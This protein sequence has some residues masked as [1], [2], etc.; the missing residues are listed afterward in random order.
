M[1]SEPLNDDGRGPLPWG[2]WLAA[3]ACLAVALL[4]LLGRLAP[5]SLRLDLGGAPTS[6]ALALLGLGPLAF[7]ASTLERGKAAPALRH[8]LAPWAL[9]A[10]LHLCVQLSGGLA[11][12]LWPAYPL[13]ILLIVRHA[14]LLPG[15]SACAV[16]LLLEGYPLWA[17]AQQDG[18]APWPRALALLLPPAGLLLGLLM[19]PAPLGAAGAQGRAARR[20]A[21]RAQEDAPPPP[22]QASASGVAPDLGVLGQ[23]LDVGA[24][25]ARDLGASLDLVFHSHPSLNSLSLWWGDEQAVSLAQLRLR[26]GQGQAAARVEAGQGHLGLVLRERHSVSIEPLAPSAAAGLPW[27]R[28]PYAAQALRVL[29]LSDEGRLVGLLAA[30]KAAEPAFSADEAA[31][32]ESLGRQLVGHAQRAA[33]LT[34]LQA[35][36]GRTQRLYEAAKALGQDLDREALLARFGALLAT[37]VASDS[38]ALGM[39]E[40]DG[41]PL[42]RVAGHGYDPAAALDMSWERSSALAGTLLQAEGALLF[43]RSEGGQVPAALL[44][45][46]QGE[47]QHFLLAPL[48]V[49]GRLSGVLKLDRR[50]QP[51]GEEERDVA[52][53]FASQAAVILEHARLYSLHLRQATTDGL[54][55]LY[56]HRY[57]QERLA[58]EVASAERTGKPLTL[59]LTD[60][61]LFKKFN[62]TFGHQEGD[63]VLRKVAKLC[64]DH[65]RPGKDIVCR[66]GGE[67]FVVIMPDCDVV[68]GRQVI[69]ALRAFSAEHMIGGSGPEARAITISVGLA[70]HPQAGRE[71]RELIHAA[72]EALYKAKQSGRNR[73]CSYKDL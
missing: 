6:A 8:P 13:L 3:L 16:L 23:G 67:E 57:F 19:E 65:V 42:L 27:A 9:L 1:A 47:A 30:D 41:G 31:A 34:R 5:L 62:D 71:P 24:L 45:G 43:N 10:L 73:V 60:I 70:T 11:S 64:Q 63:V 39:R 4:S 58:A 69:D 61:D 38:W 28:G 32:L 12:P 14:G 55:G 15:A 36:G 29:P 37:L 22:A 56:N 54:T 26:Q 33:H 72:D 52:F 50:E 21:R 46:L 48:R 66:Y 35:Q 44:E 68:E 59:A 51:F 2:A 53:I 17:H 40:D 25:L 49:G 7:Y 20:A 18:A